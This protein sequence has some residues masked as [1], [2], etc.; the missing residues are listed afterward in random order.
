MNAGQILFG[1]T[2]YLG[3]SQIERNSTHQTN[4]VC[5]SLLKRNETYPFLK[6]IL[7]GDKKW[8]VYD[9]A[10][11][12]RSWSKRDE[13]ATSTSKADIH[14]KKAMLSVW[15]DFKD[16]FY[17][18]LLPRNQNQFECLLSPANE[19]IQ[20]NWTKK[21]RKSGQN[22]QFVKTSSPIKIT[23]DHIHLWSLAKNYWS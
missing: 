4:F 11:R 13:P 9:N 10:V 19:I 20:W 5:D 22:W 16:I 18:Q 14:Q 23:P 21:S 3:S 15:W 1:H 6:R 17:F 7:T 2:S 8:V 12:K